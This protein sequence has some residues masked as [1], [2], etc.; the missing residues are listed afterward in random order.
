MRAAHITHP[1]VAAL[2]GAIG[3]VFDRQALQIHM[4]AANTDGTKTG[5]H[6]SR[7]KNKT[8]WHTAGGDLSVRRAARKRRNVMANRRAHR[9]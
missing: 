4:G 7:G 2:L 1:L 5:R 9:G 3:G 6:I 8:K